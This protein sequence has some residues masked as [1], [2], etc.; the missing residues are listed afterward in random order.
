M[1]QILGAILPGIYKLGSMWM[2][3]RKA[4]SDAKI[5]A[6]AAVVE[7]RQE[8]NSLAQQG[9][10]ASLKD[11]FLV[12]WTTGLVTLHFFPSVQPHLEHGWKMLDTVAP[13]WFGY[14][15]VGMYVAVFGLKGWK[16]FKNNG[17]K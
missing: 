7:G 1:I 13:D 17:G 6:A 12:L 4:K 14:C 5:A 16:I 8:Y 15:F 10:A 3:N 11:E 9:M 2:A